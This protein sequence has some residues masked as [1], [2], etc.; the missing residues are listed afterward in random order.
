MQNRIKYIIYGILFGLALSLLLLVLPSHDYLLYLT[1][2]PYFL[3]SITIRSGDLVSPST[4]VYFIV[5][6][7]FIGYLFS[8]KLNKK[9]LFLFIFI[10]IAGHILFLNLGGKILFKETVDTIKELI[11]NDYIPLKIPNA[12]K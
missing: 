11:D 6:F 4:F 12:D 9:I 2:A 7:A 1:A 5:I 3:D 10:I 8:S